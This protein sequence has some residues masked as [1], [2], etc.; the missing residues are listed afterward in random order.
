MVKAISL[1]KDA[2]LGDVA[3]DPEQ[4]NLT[5]RVFSAL[6]RHGKE[7]S[8]LRNEYYSMVSISCNVGSIPFFLLQES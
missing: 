8:F 3:D 7:L 1:L 6:T 4:D 5:R 2:S